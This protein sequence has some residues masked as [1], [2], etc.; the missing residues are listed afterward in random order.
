VKILF[1]GDTF[2]P[3]L[4]VLLR[5]LSPYHQIYTAST[6]QSVN[7]NHFTIRSFLLKESIFLKTREQSPTRSRGLLLISLLLSSFGLLIF[8]FR[9]FLRILELPFQVFP[10][11]S[12]IKSI[13][14]DLVV[15]YRTQTEGYLCSF[16]CPNLYILFSQGSDFSFFA[17]SDPLHYLLTSFT[18]ARSRGLISDTPRDLLLASKLSYQQAKPRIVLPGQLGISRYIYSTP[19]VPNHQTT[20]V[21]IRPPAPYIDFTVVFQALS[22]VQSLPYVPAFHLKVLAPS[23]FHSYLSHKAAST[24]FNLSSLSYVPFIDKRELI[25]LF[26]STDIVV[27]PSLTDGLPVTLLEAMGAGCVPVAS[28]LDSLSHIILSGQNGF[29]CEPGSVQ[30]YI[31]AFHYLVTNPSFITK[32]STLNRSIIAKHFDSSDNL[33]N[34]NHFFESV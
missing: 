6:R 21:L 25:S 24:G 18:L 7:E 28:Y 1:V 16:A 32:A 22:I 11:R 19:R 29:L 12:Y 27:S 8:R 14:P 26:L 34:I 5:R 9:S 10:L 31:D 17:F 20:I 13:Q 23:N 15:A 33:D 30:S 2:S 4:T 3:N